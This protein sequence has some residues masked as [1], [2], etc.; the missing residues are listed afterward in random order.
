MWRFCLSS[1]GS[2]PPS[3]MQQQ[4]C[5][6]VFPLHNISSHSQLCPCATLLHCAGSE[7]AFGNSLCLEILMVTNNFSFI[8]KRKCL[9][10]SIHQV[11]VYI[12][13]YIILYIYTK[14]ILRSTTIK[15]YRQQL[16]K[17]NSLAIT[18]CTQT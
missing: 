9:N 15:D 6:I 2:H 18:N 7:P 12:N 16:L 5:H 13:I 17:I 3:L 14:V 11:K 4:R 1:M 10:K 8:N